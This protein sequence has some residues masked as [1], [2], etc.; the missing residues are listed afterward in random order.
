MALT[1][2]KEKLI[3]IMK[4]IK[5]GIPDFSGFVQ[6]IKSR[7]KSDSARRFPFSTV[8]IGLGGLLVILLVLLI[9]ISF[10]RSGRSTTDT[11]EL[12]SLAFVIST[13]DL[14]LPAE[15]E[16]L[17]EFLL[18]QEPRSSWS[19]EDIRPFW[20]APSNTEIWRNEIRSEAERFLE[21]AR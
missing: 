13:E 1:D 10:S 19:I 3:D 12:M 14:F 20:I 16:F 5:D 15:P 21:G 8:L 9:V 6:K 11:N 4:G 7:P 18:E 2:I 17:P